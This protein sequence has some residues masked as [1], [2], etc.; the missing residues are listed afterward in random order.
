MIIHLVRHTR[1]NLP[2]GLCYGQ[3]DVPVMDNWE[4][5]AESIIQRFDYLSN[6]LVFSSPLTRCSLLAEK[7][8][9]RV[10]LDNRLKELNFGDWELKPWD[11][12]SGA[13]A[14]NWMNNFVVTRCPNGESYLD[15]YKRVKSFLSELCNYTD[16]EVIIVTHGGVIRAIVCSI[17]NIPLHKSFEINVNHGQITSL[18]LP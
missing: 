9:T 10:N 17:E 5:E 6:P 1:V 2:Q 16:E 12:I 14:E 18:A 3:S 4:T 13:E 15:L 8:S 7:I 11:E